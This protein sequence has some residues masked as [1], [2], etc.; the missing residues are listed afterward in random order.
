M[1]YPKNIIEFITLFNTE[2]QCLLYLEAIRWNLEFPKCKRG[3]FWRHKKRRVRICSECR[4]V[5]SVT[6][7][8]VL[9]RLR[10]PLRT[11]FLLCWF[12]V[13]SKQ[14]IRADELSSILWIS[15]KTSW[16]WCNKIRKIMILDDRKKL[17]WDI[18]VYEV[19]IWLKWEVIRWRW[20][21]WKEKV[22]IAVE[23][24]T[25][26]KNKEWLYRWMWR[27]RAKVI[28]NCSEKTLT[29]FITENIEEWNTIYTDWWLWYK[30]IE[31]RWYKHIIEK[32]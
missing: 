17:S 27:V 24:N 21:K 16:L 12:M 28:P 19:F 13:T 29:K 18:E 31:S 5:L 8:T 32:S 22:V 14:W 26:S 9:D 20:A 10:I 15:I 7:W 25:T 4:S 1:N 23:K 6:A 3:K 11:L 2:E 30:N